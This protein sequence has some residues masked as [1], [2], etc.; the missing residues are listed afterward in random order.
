MRGAFH[1]SSSLCPTFEPTLSKREGYTRPLNTAQH[2]PDRA[3]PR[4][5]M[6]QASV[7]QLGHFHNHSA[8]SRRFLWGIPNRT[9]LQVSNLAKKELTRWSRS[10][11][12]RASASWH[13]DKP[14]GSCAKPH[15]G[16]MALC[17]TRILPTSNDRN[18]LMNCLRKTASLL[19]RA[20]SSA[21]PPLWGKIDPQE[22]Q[23]PSQRQK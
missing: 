16:V 14:I 6:C 7:R 4:R 3:C 8:P 17:P 10:S 18:I 21:A 23:G 2:T 11:R 20:L 9:P 22:H 1:T 15:G 13:S 12:C 5:K 19:T